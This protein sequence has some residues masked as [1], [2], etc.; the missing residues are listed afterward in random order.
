MQQLRNTAGQQGYASMS[1]NMY[2]VFADEDNT[3]TTATT[4][5]NI[6]AL[7]TGS[8]IMVTIPD[9]VANAINQLS[10]EQT[11]LMNQMA[12]MLY[13]NVPPPLQPYNINH[14]SNNSPF[15]CS[16]LLPGPH[17]VVSTMEMEEVAGGA[18]LTGVRWTWGRA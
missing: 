3:D 13:A 7:M 2:N 9:S 17:Q 1:H 6:A 4:A 11:A 15:Q 10:A 14:Q 18:Q 8:T 16:N 5:T 12:A